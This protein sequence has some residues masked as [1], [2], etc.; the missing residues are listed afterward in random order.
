MPERV[1]RTWIPDWFKRNNWWRREYPSPGLAVLVFSPWGCKPQG[2]LLGKFY[3]QGLPQPDPEATPVGN[4]Q[5]PAAPAATEAASVYL[6]RWAPHPSADTAPGTK[7]SPRMP[8]PKTVPPK[9]MPVDEATS[10]RA[11]PPPVVVPSSLPVA[12]SGARRAAEALVRRTWLTAS[13]LIFTGGEVKNGNG[14]TN[15]AHETWSLLWGEGYYVVGIGNYFNFLMEQTAI[16]IGPEQTRSPWYRPGIFSRRRKSTTRARLPA[17][18]DIRV[19]LGEDLLQREE[20][21]AKLA[22]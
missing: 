16:P 7:P 4:K 22:H 18:V 8:A 13:E 17:E 5:P 21:F 11:A 10:V 20:A 14:R 3:Q 19:T 9:Q 2:S 1:R 6:A 15:H 12:D